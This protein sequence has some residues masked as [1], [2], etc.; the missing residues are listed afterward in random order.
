MKTFQDLYIVAEQGELERFKSW[1]LELIDKSPEWKVEEREDLADFLLFRRNQTN[2]IQSALLFLKI[3][4]TKLSV[5]NIIPIHQSNLSFD[6]YNLILKD[7]YENFVHN[8][9]FNLRIEVTADNL[10][11]QDIVGQAVADKLRLFSRA[12]NK[13]TGSSHPLDKQR[14]NDFVITSFNNDM[15]IDASTLKR[16]LTEEEGWDH[17]IASDLSVDYEKAISLLAQYEEGNN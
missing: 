8:N 7:F 10:L 9:P 6:E 5:S 13:S 1:L 12:A 14:W 2:G 11:L 4:D 15:I 3:T 17:N 16:W